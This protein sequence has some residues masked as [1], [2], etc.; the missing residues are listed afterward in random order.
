ME[1]LFGYA[2]I[3]KDCAIIEI[4]Y[5]TQTARDILTRLV[6][7]VYPETTFQWVYFEKNLEAAN[8]NCINDP[9]RTK[10]QAF[11]NIEKNQQWTHS[12]EIPECVEVIKIFRIP[13]LNRK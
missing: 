11:G 3:G 1:T 9:K 4:A 13:P 2:C 8:W 6:H 12:Y 5:I 10:E 7:E